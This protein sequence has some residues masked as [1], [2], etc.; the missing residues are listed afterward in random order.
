LPFLECRARL[1]I[2]N[3]KG[4]KELAIQNTETEEQR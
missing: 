1:K 4:K 2:R 3:K